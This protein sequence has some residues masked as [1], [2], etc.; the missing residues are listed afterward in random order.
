MQNRV[1]AMVRMSEI[2]EEID[3]ESSLSRYWDDDLEEMA[4][5]WKRKFMDVAAELFDSGVEEGKREAS[6]F[7]GA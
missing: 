6:G 1:A 7:Y 2:F 3:F 4:D 5:D